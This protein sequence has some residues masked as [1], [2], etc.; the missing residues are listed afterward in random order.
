MRKLSNNN[1]VIKAYILNGYKVVATKQNL[2]WVK[3]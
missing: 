1:Q 3:L 2:C